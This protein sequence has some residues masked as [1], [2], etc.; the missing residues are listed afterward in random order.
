MAE[1]HG[2]GIRQKQTDGG[3]GGVEG[4]RTIYGPK[5]ILL[6]TYL[7]QLGPTLYLFHH[8][9]IVHSILNLSMD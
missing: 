1:G 6:V 8:L 4:E 9:P 7:L 2:R 3:G 5:Y